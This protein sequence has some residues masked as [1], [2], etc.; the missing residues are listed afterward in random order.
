MPETDRPQLKLYSGEPQHDVFPRLIEMFP[1][2]RMEPEAP[3]PF[4]RGPEFTLPIEFSFD[5]TARSVAD[6][7]VNEIPP[8]DHKPILTTYTTP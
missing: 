4:P 8:S 2:G 6:F 3:G 7:L 1:T 5:G